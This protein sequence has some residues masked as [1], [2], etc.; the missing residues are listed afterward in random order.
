MDLKK[1]NTFWTIVGSI[2]VLVFLF[3]LVRNL[4]DVNAIIRGAGVGGPFIAIF[5]FA[6][7]AATPIPTDPLTVV[8]GVI[9][10]P[11]VGSIISWVGNNI[12]ALVEYYFG[13]HVR[14]V[15]N[16]DQSLKKLP[17]GLNNVAVDSPIFLIFARLIPGYGGKV[18]SFVAGIHHVPIRRYIWTTALTNLIG[19]L[20]LSFGGYHFIHLFKF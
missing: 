19:A 3:F 1:L 7:F 10:G 5:L 4:R 9:F 11:V 2:V 6:I 13:L 18:I 20:V 8:C 15:T 17:F 16:I 12:A 14:K